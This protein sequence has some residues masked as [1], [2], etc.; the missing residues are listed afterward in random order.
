MDQ[1]Q[2][3]VIVSAFLEE[4]DLPRRSRPLE[5]ESALFSGALLLGGVCRRWMNE[6]GLVRN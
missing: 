3:H 5:K 1:K 6:E 2:V 4:M